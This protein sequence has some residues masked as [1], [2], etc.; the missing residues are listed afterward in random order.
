MEKKAFTYFAF[1]YEMYRFQKKKKK[2]IRLLDP[3]PKM[4]ITVIAISV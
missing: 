3:R 1:L 4:C 2:G